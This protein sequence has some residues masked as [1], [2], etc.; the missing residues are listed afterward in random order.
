MKKIVVS[1]IAAALVAG[2]AVSTAQASSRIPHVVKA[3]AEAWNAGDAAEM[4]SLFTNDGT[5]R[6]N[7]FQ[8]AMSGR[9]GVE[10][11]VN[12]TERSIR[13]AHV[14]VR[15]AFRS[16]DRVAVRWTFSGTD[17][18]AFDKTRPATGK[19]FRV[20]ASTLIDLRGERIQQVTDYYN[21]ADVLRQ[22]GLPAGPWTPPGS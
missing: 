21:L 15:D 2:S 16:G 7:A 18:G 19:S 6:D 1:G 5:Y 9:Q 20:P 22:V 14:D 17:T 10:N 3:W 11:W 13:D 4:A 8:V 12:I